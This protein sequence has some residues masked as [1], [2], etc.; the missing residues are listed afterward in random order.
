MTHEEFF[1]E[2]QNAPT[3]SARENLEAVAKE[4][5]CRTYLGVRAHG[6]GDVLLLANRKTSSSRLHDF[7]AMRFDLL[8]FSRRV[9]SLAN[10]MEQIGGSPSDKLCEA[11]RRNPLRRA[12]PVKSV[13][14]NAC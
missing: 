13:W 3:P 5:A 11:H 6:N 1:L 14:I 9:G 8:R 4:A 7:A 2:R 10:H 12:R